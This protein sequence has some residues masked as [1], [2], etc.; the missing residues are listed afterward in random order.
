[1]NGISLYP[2]RRRRICTDMEQ[3]AASTSVRRGAYPCGVAERSNAELVRRAIEGGPDGRRAWDLLVANNARAVWK[4]LWS[5]RM[6]PTDR[7]DVFQGTWL[8]A[9]ER[10]DQLREPD[11]LHVWLMT[12]AR[13][14]AEGLLRKSGRSAPVA[15]TPET[16]VAPVDADRLEH[17]ERYRIARIALDRL[18]D[19][20]RELI[21]LLTIDQ[22][23]YR[24]IERSMGWAEGGT[25][26]RRSRCLEKVRKTPEVSRY[27]RDLHAIEESRELS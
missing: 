22:M 19:D 1:M 13:H 12:I 3:R 6:S 25:A 15:E 14:E 26:I 5:F 8:R 24:D 11:K 21:R 20:C 2:R 18:G 7:E 10:L 16:P 17:D 23:T 9:L 4:V 27:L